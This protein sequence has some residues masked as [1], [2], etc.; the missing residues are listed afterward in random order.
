MSTLRITSGT[1]RGRQIPVPTHELRPTSEKARQAF[2]NMVAGDLVG[3]RFL[4]LFAGSGVFSFEAISRGAESAVA[5]EASPS[6]VR[7][8]AKLAQEWNLPI[9]AMATD[10]VAGIRRLSQESPFHVVF[11]DPPYDYAQYTELLEAI[12]SGVPMAE[13]ATVAIEHRSGELPWDQSIELTRLE[14]R[15]TARY[16]NVSI[17]LFDAV[18]DGKCA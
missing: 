3:A 1:L 12:D 4:D 14:I 10:V 2:F 15:R 17:T 11:A 7:E 5:I 8:I 18:V 9:T 16:G 13:D 6:S